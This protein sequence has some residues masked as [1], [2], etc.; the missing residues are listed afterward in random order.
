MDKKR[1]VDLIRDR[2]GSA[3]IGTSEDGAIMEME[4]I[5]GRLLI[6]KERSV[7]ELIMADDIDL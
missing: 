5:A 4:N 7:Y 2:G 3:D 1:P 6:I